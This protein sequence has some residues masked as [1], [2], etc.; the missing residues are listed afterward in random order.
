MQAPAPLHVPVFP[1]GGEA[2][3]C[4]PGAAVPAGSGAQLPSPLMLQAWQVGQV[5]LP[6]QMPSV[7]LPL[8]HWLAPV[9]VWPFGLR[10]QLRL[11]PVPWQVNGA[12]QSPSAVQAVL[13][14]AFV[15]QV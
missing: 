7:Q 4:V 12:M 14:V 5:W 10:A 15:L 13:Q 2:G 11:V 9:Q 1:H 3:H 6:Q 8:M